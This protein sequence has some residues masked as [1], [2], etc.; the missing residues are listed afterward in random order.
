MESCVTVRVTA[1]IDGKPSFRF[2]K[3]C[4]AALGQVVCE[5]SRSEPLRLFLDAA[6]EIKA[7]DAFRGKCLHARRPV[8]FPRHADEKGSGMA[9]ANLLQAAILQ[10][11]TSRPFVGTSSFDASQLRQHSRGSIQYLDCMGNTIGNLLQD[12]TQGTTAGRS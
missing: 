4:D 2:S 11:G 5:V 7:Q 9:G 12:Q 10:S 1:N 6:G 8:A 3:Y